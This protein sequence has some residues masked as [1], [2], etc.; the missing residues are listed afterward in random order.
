M[1]SKKDPG[2]PAGPN[3]GFSRRGFLGVGLG[4]GA[5][6]V[7]LLETPR[8]QQFG[9]AARPLEEIFVVESACDR[10]CFIKL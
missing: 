4:S 10:L 1:K 5:V 6:G 2:A 9:V 7:G 3:P 8:A